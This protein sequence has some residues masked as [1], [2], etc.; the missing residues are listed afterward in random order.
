MTE[1]TVA[2]GIGSTNGCNKGTDLVLE[3]NL[4]NDGW[5]SLVLP[6]LVGG[7]MSFVTSVSCST[8]LGREEEVVGI[9]GYLDKQHRFA[10]PLAVEKRILEYCHDKRCHRWW[11][12]YGENEHTEKFVNEFR[13]KI[14]PSE[15]Q[16]RGFFFNPNPGGP[17][18]G[19]WEKHKLNRRTRDVR[20][21]HRRSDLVEI[22][23]EHAGSSIVLSKNCLFWT[24][25]SKPCLSSKL[26][27]VISGTTIASS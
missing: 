20:E 16:S 9:A 6:L 21:L 2:L 1:L 14:I 24:R 7:T 5:T 3:V 8:T 27:A 17:L 23:K 26:S 11:D 15:N 19:K 13:N 4:D 10:V 18:E 25:V 22:T 12:N